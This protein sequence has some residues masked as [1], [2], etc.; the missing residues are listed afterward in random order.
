[1]SASLALNQPTSSS[2][3]GQASG[4]QFD[5][6]GQ[7]K[8]HK[9][10]QDPCV[11]LTYEPTGPDQ[12]KLN[13]RALRPGGSIWSRC[14]KLESSSNSVAIDH[15][16]KRRRRTF[17]VTKPLQPESLQRKTRGAKSG[18]AKPAKKNL[19]EQNLGGQILGNKTWRSKT[20]R[21]KIW[22]STTQ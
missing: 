18:R 5:A 4:P 13:R 1:M 15:V 20:W 3:I 8:K 11:S 19:S 16:E 7:T 14:S 22:R 9:T 10:Y 17:S 12:L 21:S 2:A 6:L